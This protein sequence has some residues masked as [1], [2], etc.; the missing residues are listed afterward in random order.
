MCDGNSATQGFSLPPLQELKSGLN[1]GLYFESLYFDPGSVFGSDCE[2]DVEPP[3]P[4]KRRKPKCEVSKL[5]CPF[6]K[7]FPFEKGVS[8]SCKEPGFDNI[9]RLK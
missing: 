6:R 9:G 7:A 1:P 8:R 4:Q 2:L 3:R 5:A